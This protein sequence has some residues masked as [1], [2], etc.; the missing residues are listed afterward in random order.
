MSLGELGQHIAVSPTYTNPSIPRVKLLYTLLTAMRLPR[1]AARSNTSS[2]AQSLDRSIVRSLA[3]SYYSKYLLAGCSL[4]RLI[5]WWIAFESTVLRL[6][7]SIHVWSSTYEPSE[8]SMHLQV[9]SSQHDVYM[10]VSILY[11]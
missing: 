1:I 2:S 4:D 10:A 5:D 3:T 9:L 6:E 7:H 8:L 11:L